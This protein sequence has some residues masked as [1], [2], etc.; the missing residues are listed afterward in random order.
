MNLSILSYSGVSMQIKYRP[1]EY[2]L[3]IYL[4]AA[5]LTTFLTI[6]ATDLVAF[7]FEVPLTAL[8]NFLAVFSIAFWSFLTWALI[9]FLAS[10]AA[11]STGS[12]TLA[13]LTAFVL[14]VFAVFG[15]GLVT[16]GFSEVFILKWSPQTPAVT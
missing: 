4:A 8:T 9:T 1:E 14:V 13:G 5:F 3:Q 15:A 7:F 10:L 16:A 6:L 11:A 12:T 2:L